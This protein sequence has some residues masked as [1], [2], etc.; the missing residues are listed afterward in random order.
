MLDFHVCSW[1]SQPQLSNQDD[2]LARHFDELNEP[3]FSATLQASLTNTAASGPTNKPACPVP[4]MPRC[5]SLCIPTYLP[6][7]CPFVHLPPQCIEEATSAAGG[8]RPPI[9]SFSHFLPR[10]DLRPEKRMR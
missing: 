1:G 9:I 2:S 10:Q 3:G 8:V 7:A 4:C 6:T 5:L